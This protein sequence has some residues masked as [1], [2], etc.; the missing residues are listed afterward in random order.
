MILGRGELN[1][2]T[3]FSLIIFFPDAL[4][5]CEHFGSFGVLIREGYTL[6]PT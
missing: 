3:I 4:F 5:G 6:G 1:H 2:V